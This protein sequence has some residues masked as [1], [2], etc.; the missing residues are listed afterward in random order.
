MSLGSSGYK[1]LVVWFRWIHS[2][3]SWGLLGSFGVLVSFRCAL[4]VIR[5]TRSRWFTSGAPCGSL[6]SFE[7][8]LFISVRPGIVIMFILALLFHSCAPSVPLGSF[9]FVGSIRVRAWDYFVHSW[10][11]GFILVMIRGRWVHS[12]GLSAWLALFRDVVFIW[13]CPWG[14]WVHSGWLGSSGCTQGP[15]GFI[16]GH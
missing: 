8:A 1:L 10:S 13:V 9:G 11:F 16:R 5:F 15:F 4:G 7:I 3:A 2:G 14:R 12:V 6:V